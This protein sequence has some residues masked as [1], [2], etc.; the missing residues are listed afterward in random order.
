MATTYTLIASSTVG[1]SGASSID[2]T[3]IPSTYTDLVVKVSSR[4]SLL[5]GTTELR[6]NLNGSAANFTGKYL[7]GTGAAAASGSL[8]Q[9]AGQTETGAY[10]ALTFSSHD[11]YIPNAFGSTNKSYSAD[12]VTENN[13]TTGYQDLIAGLWSQTAAINQVT[14]SLASGNFVQY[15]TAYLYGVKNA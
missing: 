4:T 14:L 3:S 8:A 6:L 13:G 1:L 9:Y 2:F 5:S 10:T 12:A 15:S 7:L 11:I